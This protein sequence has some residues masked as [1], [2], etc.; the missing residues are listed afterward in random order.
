M[1]QNPGQMA[2]LLFGQDNS[3][4]DEMISISDLRQLLESLGLTN[5]KANLVARYLV[6]I[7]GQGD[8][9]FNENLTANVSDVL[10]SM[11]KLIGYYCLYK[12]EGSDFDNDPNYVQEE[13][14]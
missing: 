9:I 1:S 6:E 7:P 13:Y 11:T 2:M 14:M 8:L 5:K 3:N 4:S 12:P 10:D